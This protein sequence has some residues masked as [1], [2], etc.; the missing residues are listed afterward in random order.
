MATIQEQLQR[1]RFPIDTWD[2]KEKLLL[3]S[4]VV[5]SGDQ[6]WMSVSRLMKT[7]GHTT[8]PSDWYSQKN[9]AAQYGLLL[10]NVETPKR[11]KRTNS[12][13][14]VMETPS[15]S[16]LRKLREERMIELKRIMNEERKLY[17]KLKEE[18]IMVKSGMLIRRRNGLF[19]IPVWQNAFM[20]CKEIYLCIYCQ[21]SLFF[22][23][24]DRIREILPY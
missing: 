13:E 16:I 8:R 14:T 5:R 12:S 10:E 22:G 15:E 19:I 3:A 23:N 11:K 18:I 21:N 17:L 4:A 2:I 1:K 24:K 6:N 20:H 9:C 7:L